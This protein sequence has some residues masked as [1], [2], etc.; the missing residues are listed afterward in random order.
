MVVTKRKS[1][2]IDPIDRAGDIV[3]MKL[4]S[5]SCDGWMSGFPNKTFENDRVAGAL[6]D[7]S[8]IV[9]AREKF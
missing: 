2:R 4:L 1:Q 5:C 9:D 6:M 8:G 7:A 3:L